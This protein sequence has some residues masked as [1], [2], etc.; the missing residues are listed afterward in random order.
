MEQKP[1]QPQYPLVPLP[2]PTQMVNIVTLEFI[3]GNY[4]IQL[5]LAE[6]R[7]APVQKIGDLVGSAMFEVGRFVL[8]PRALRN[9]LD[10]A[11]EAAQQYESATGSP[12]PSESQFLAGVA[13]KDLLK[14]PAN[15]EPP[16]SES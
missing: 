7:P 13:M 4:A 9:L 10:K 6:L 11:Q 16:K 15:P 14:P 12:L 5:N 2:T 1:Q 8:T 3:R